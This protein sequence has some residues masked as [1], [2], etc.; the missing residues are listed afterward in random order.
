MGRN[1]QS[2]YRQ[3]CPS[4]GAVASASAPL[5]LKIIVFSFLIVAA[6]S[7]VFLNVRRADAGILLDIPAILK[8]NVLYEGAGPLAA[9]PALFG[10]RE[11]SSSKLR[12]FTKWSAMFSRFDAQLSQSESLPQ[13]LQGLKVNLQAFEGQSLASMAR[14][15]NRLINAR[16]YIT[17]SRNWGQ[18][19]YW[20]TPL[21]F[22]QRGGDCEDFAITKYV[23]LKMLG[24]PEERLRIAIVQDTLKNIPHAILIVYTAEGPLLL[25]NQQSQAVQASTAGRY[26]PI[27]SINRQAW[28]LHSAPEASSTRVASAY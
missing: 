21:E 10:S 16:P 9:Y 7:I 3:T 4:H 8:V 5:F 27:F 2:K 18:S 24:V 15:V 22:L 19:D 23:A 26:R 13:E 25:D 12:A 17:D 14:G 6:L 11:R 28:W 20:A 1:G